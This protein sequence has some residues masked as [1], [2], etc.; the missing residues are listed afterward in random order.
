MMA[1]TPVHRQVE[2]RRMEWCMQEVLEPHRD[3]QGPRFVATDAGIRRMCLF[4][5]FVCTEKHINFEKCVAK[6]V[7][8][9]VLDSGAG[10][11]PCPW[12]GRQS[13]Y[14][15]DEAT[16]LRVS[17]THCRACGPAENTVQQARATWN[18]I[19]PVKM[20]GKT[21]RKRK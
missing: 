19:K 6:S 3:P 5:R 10:L 13:E 16:G 8:D 14:R 17:C 11:N 1:K 12:C 9:Y 2:M 4:L 7:D 21:K 20:T 18:M 15:G